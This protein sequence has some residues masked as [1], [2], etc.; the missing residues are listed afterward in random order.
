[1]HI[2]NTCTHPAILLH[3]INRTQHASIKSITISLKMAYL[4][5]KTRRVPV[6]W[7]FNTKCTLHVTGTYWF[8][9]LPHI[10]HHLS[11]LNTAGLL[12]C[13]VL[14]SLLCNSVLFVVLCP[15]FLL[16]FIVLVTLFTVLVTLHCSCYFVHCS[17]YCSLFL[18]LC[19]LFLLLFIVLV[20]LFTVL[21]TLF[22]VL[23]TV[24]CSC[25]VLP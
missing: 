6:F 10:W 14:F 15:M 22:T 5:S 3:N 7:G 21:V 2:A 25:I 18:L 11:L 20:T 13:N 1:V 23:V 17:C 12:A 24:H 16:L 8:H 19:S 4:I 9:V